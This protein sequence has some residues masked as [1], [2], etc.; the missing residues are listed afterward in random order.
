[1]NL[2]GSI[3][4]GYARIEQAKPYLKHTA[5]AYLGFMYVLPAYRGK[6]INKNNCAGFGTVVNNTKCI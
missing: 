3:D 4:A 1:V 6:G 5:Y 2:E